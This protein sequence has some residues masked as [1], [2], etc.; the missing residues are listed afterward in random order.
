MMRKNKVN[1]LLVKNKNNHVTGIITFGAMLWKTG[2]T[3]EV[4]NI[5]QHAAPRQE[6]G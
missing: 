4:S 6:C 5:L 1:R 2:D 3:S